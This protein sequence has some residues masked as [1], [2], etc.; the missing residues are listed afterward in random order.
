[1]SVR[2]CRRCRNSARSHTELVEMVVIVAESGVY[3]CPRRRGGASILGVV[4]APDQQGDG[5]LSASAVRLLRRPRPRFRGYLHRWAALASIPLGVTL[6]VLAQGTRAQ[7]SM[8]VYSLGITAMLGVSAV[9]HGRDWPARKVEL[10]VRIDH[11]VIFVMFGT[12]A[13]PIALLGLD[14]P[15]SVLLLAVAWT[16]ALL[17][18]IGVWAPMHPRAGVMNGAYLGFGWSMVVFAPWLIMSLSILESVLL[19]AGG[20]AYTLGAVVVGAR[21]PDPWPDTFGYHEIWHVHVVVAIVC[22]TLLLISLAY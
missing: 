22:H 17:G 4:T 10:L 8:L 2:G 18:I 20:A 14:S 15:V 3:R 9:V 16:G 7:L 13:T 11:S 6:T 21:R 5:Q 12:C 19:F 1:M